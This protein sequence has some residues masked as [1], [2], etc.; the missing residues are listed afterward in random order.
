MSSTPVDAT[1][2]EQKMQPRT[3][4]AAA[5]TRKRHASTA[6]FPNPEPA[7]DKRQ[8]SGIITA[9]NEG[10]EKET[11]ATVNNEKKNATATAESNDDEFSQLQQFLANHPNRL[12]TT[13]KGICTPHLPCMYRL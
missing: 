5:E 9:S 1:Q 6:E 10:E 3:T 8:C 2:D 11:K 4:K 13:I 12:M 7:N